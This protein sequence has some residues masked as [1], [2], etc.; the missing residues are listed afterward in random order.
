MRYE[1]MGDT[2]VAVSAL[3]FG[4]MSFGGDA[5]EDTSATLFHRCREV[6][7][8]LFDCADVYQSGRAEE[9]LG[10]LVKDCR[11]EVILATKAFYPMG[12]DVNAQGASRRHI[13]RAAEAS[14][15]RLKTE[16]IDL[17]YIH[18]I[19]ISTGSMEGPRWRKRSVRWTISCGRGRS[20]MRR[21]AT[22]RRGRWRRASASRHAQGSRRSSASNPCTT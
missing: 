12:D 20:S 6:G 13:L 10:T 2:G 21:R 3:G 22:S 9:T 19:H 16:Y 17:Y 7:I 18:Y 15:R 4:T 1:F 11:D 8:N 14:L 5:D